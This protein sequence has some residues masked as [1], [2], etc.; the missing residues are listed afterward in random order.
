MGER[1][2]HLISL[3][4]NPLK[5]SPGVLT[6]SNLPNNVPIINS[7]LNNMDF[8][9]LIDSGA[10][11]NLLY[12]DGISSLSR[13][14]IKI[15][16]CNVQLKGF[17]NE[18][19]TVNEKA[20]LPIQISGKTF[21]TEFYISRSL[22]QPL[23]YGGILGNTFLT[24]NLFILDFKNKTLKNSSVSVPFLHSDHS[25]LHSNSSVSSS[26][27]INTFNHSQNCYSSGTYTFEPKTEKIVK[28]HA[29]NNFLNNTYDT[30][31]LEPVPLSNSLLVGRSVSKFSSKNAYFVK[32]ANFTSKTLTLQKN[33]KIATISPIQTVSEF[34][35]NIINSNSEFDENP[36]EVW[37]E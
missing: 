24:D 20:I 4:E 21:E 28:V 16:P 25:N 34:S 3:S 26:N 10:N 31:L 36:F 11:I 18:N 15:I 22:P 37:G 35:V 17:S 12:F 27:L 29:N 5:V 2:H 33:C 8:P 30:V 23:S 32:I 9:L 13:N 1:R 7:K 14:L 6:L 19:I